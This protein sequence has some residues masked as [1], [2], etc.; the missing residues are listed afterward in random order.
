MLNACKYLSRAHALALIIH[1]HTVP[2]ELTDNYINYYS[3]MKC[4][5]IVTLNLMNLGV[6]FL[7]ITL[8]HAANYTIT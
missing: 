7:N 2:Y 3:L 1:L 5:K 8:S 6:L 4:H